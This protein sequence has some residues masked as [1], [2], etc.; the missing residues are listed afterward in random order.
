MNLCYIWKGIA[1]KASI[2]HPSYP[3]TEVKFT[4]L[5]ITIP[6]ASA[7]KGPPC[8]GKMNV[9]FQVTIQ[10]YPLGISSYLQVLSN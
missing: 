4:G 9:V 3:A 2:M 1:S 10:M 8:H 6:M 7:C 5:L